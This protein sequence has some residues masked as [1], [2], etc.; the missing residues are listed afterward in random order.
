M[1]PSIADVCTPICVIFVGSQKPS[2]QWLRTHAKPLTVR[3]EYVR[4]ALQW[5]QAHNPLYD[6]ATLQ[7]FPENDVLPYHIEHLE[8]KNSDDYEALTSQYEGPQ[9]EVECCEPKQVLFENVVVMDVDGNASSNH[10]RAAAMRYIKEKG[11]SY[12]QIPHDSKPVN[13]F[14]NPELFPMI[15][16]TLYPYSIGGFE[17]SRRQVWVSLKRHVKHLFNLN[18]KRFQE[19]HSFMFTVFNI[20]QRCAILLHTSLKV[21]AQNFASVAA[22]LNAISEQSAMCVIEWRTGTPSPF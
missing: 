17:D 20:L 2:K 7:T 5:L 9:A 12:V 16:P 11:G 15:Y 1:P 8:P 13:E 22:T 10:L 4:R 21:K 3:R 14:F 18:D 19:H 6:Y